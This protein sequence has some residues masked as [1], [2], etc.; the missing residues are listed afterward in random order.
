VASYPIQPPPRTSV[1]EISGIRWVI[2]PYIR[3]LITVTEDAQAS[4]EVSEGVTGRHPGD[5]Y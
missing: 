2:G 1:T 3:D 5:R 4:C